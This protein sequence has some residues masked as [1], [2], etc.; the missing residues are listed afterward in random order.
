MPDGASWCGQCYTVVGAARPATT[1]VVPAAT[2]TATAPVGVLTATAPLRQAAPPTAA[3]GGDGRLLGRRAIVLVVVAIGL[4]G[5]AQLAGE[6]IGRH[7]T[8]EPASLIRYDLAL[9]LGMYAVVGVLIASQITPSIRLRWGDGP[10]WGRIAVGALVGATISGTLLALV[11]AAS[12]HLDP[13]PRFVLTMSEGDP[14]HIVIT[15]G[16]A[17]IAAPLVEETLFRG[18]LLE[19][20]RGRGTG[21]AIL[22]SALAFAVW[23]FM[24]N[25]LIYY[26]AMGVTLGRLY[27]RR[28]LAA[29]MA[30]HVAFNGVLVVAAISVVLGPATRTEVQGLS[31]ELPANWSAAV[32]L[33]NGTEFRGPSDAAMAI[34]D[35]PTP[36]APSLADLPSRLEQDH[37]ISVEA[38]TI[39]D[40]ALPIGSAV[41]AD[42]LADGHAGTVVLIPRA[43]TS[44][45]LLLL[46]AG[47]DRATHDF[48]SILDSARRG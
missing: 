20:L 40:V 17:C 6:L 14:T 5:L 25:A 29:S 42:V 22:V 18:L 30:A 11:S 46:S 32:T 16:I 2:A 24:P 23:H 10:L 21:A 15:A 35:F 43:G 41:E 47:S 34:E 38:S 4:G 13:D 19:S 3:D 45:E 48:E 28:G 31:V 37:D 44:Y 8:L 27:L 39:R 36:V 1:T 33:T 9:T 26:T 12:G 7:T